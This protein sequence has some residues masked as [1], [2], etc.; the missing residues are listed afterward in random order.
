MVRLF[1]EM[2]LM[3]PTAGGVLGVAGLCTPACACAGIAKASIN[4]Q[5]GAMTNHWDTLHLLKR[6]NRIKFSKNLRSPLLSSTPRHCLV[7]KRTAQWIRRFPANEPLHQ[8]FGELPEQ[9]RG[10][11]REKKHSE[12]SHFHHRRQRR[13]QSYQFYHPAV[14]RIVVPRS[15]LSPGVVMLGIAS[16]ETIPSQS[17]AQSSKK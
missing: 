8:V 2:D 5:L 4:P 14:S 1:P 12:H 9:V 17:L 13:N 16:K 11:E 15:S 3:V 7:L 6:Q 10:K